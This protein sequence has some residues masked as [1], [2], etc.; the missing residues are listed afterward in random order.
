VKGLLL[1]NLG[2]PDEPMVPDVR[3]YLREFLG[4][5]RVLDM[6]AV[7]RW[8]LLNFVILPFR[9]RRSAHAYLKIWDPRTGSPLLHH[10]RRLADA[11]AAEVGAEWKVALAMRYGRPGIDA[12]LDAL[13]G[14]DPVVVLPLYPQVATSTTSSTLAAVYEA[15]AR[16]L[17][18]VSLRAIRGFHL[19][20]GWLAAQVERIR[21]TLGEADHLVLS[22]HGIPERHVRKADPT[23]SHCLASAGCCATPSPAH[24]VCYRAQCVQGARAIAAA[25]GLPSDRW[26]FAF[27][28]RMGRDPWLGPATADVLAALPGKG[29]KSVVVAC[30]S[31]V[32]DCLETLEEIGLVGAASFREAGGDRFALVPCLND[33]PA[34]V[35]VVA[36]LAADAAG[37]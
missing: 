27:Q 15:A 1:V 37:S 17:D 33:D 14:C 24:A 36:A 21:P 2:T 3:S 32:A 29:V 13:A 28:S 10:S 5:P 4:D 31:F 34:W 12:G 35:R 6:P 7:L 30:P 26:S 18:P 9:P 20:P 19:D 11:V 25:L 16:R 22:F 8:L 23:G